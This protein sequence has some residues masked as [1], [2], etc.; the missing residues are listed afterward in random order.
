[1]PKLEKV[2]QNLR[3]YAKMLM[4]ILVAMQMLILMPML[5]AMQIIMLWRTYF[6]TAYVR[7]FYAVFSF[8]AERERESTLK[9]DRKRERE[10]ES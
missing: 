9:K 3:K 4:L 5:V 8:F 10:S 2:C 7:T 6:R 1:M